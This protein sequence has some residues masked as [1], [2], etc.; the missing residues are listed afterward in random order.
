[1]VEKTD[2]ILQNRYRLD[3]ILGQGGMGTVYKELK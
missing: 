1:M 3:Q 2:Q